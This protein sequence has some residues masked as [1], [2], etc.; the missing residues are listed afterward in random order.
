MS[1]TMLSNSLTDLAA[2]IKAEHAA[3]VAAIKQSLSR[4]M[5]AGDLLLEAKAQLGHGEWLPWLA[6]RCGIPERTASRYMKLARN[7]AA[8]QGRR[9]HRAQTDSRVRHRGRGRCAALRARHFS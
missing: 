6:E 3:Y 4:A 8:A 9:A 7:R 2:R 5:A 1:A